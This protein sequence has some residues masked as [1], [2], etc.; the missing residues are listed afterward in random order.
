M[1]PAKVVPEKCRGYKIDMGETSYDQYKGI[2]YALGLGM[3]KDPL[4]EKELDFTFELAEN[5]KILPSFGTVLTKFDSLLEAFMAC[6]GLPDFNALN[7]LHG[8]Q[9]L[10][11]FKPFLPSMRLFLDGEI[12]DVADKVKG[13][14]VT[15]LVNI[16]DEKGELVCRTTANIFIRGIGGFGD[17]GLSQQTI[18][19]PPKRNPDKTVTETTDPNQAILYRLSGDYNPL[20]IAPQ[21]AQ[22]AGFDKPILHGLCFYG[23]ATKAVLKEFCDY[24]VTRFGSI[25]VMVT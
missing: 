16:K 9:K 14:L 22:V 17:K 21:M 19:A 13:A 7:I 11:S 2:L 8:E 15:A 10:E 5:F 1:K 24:D 3:S 18:P 23:I 4:D 20:H 6:P 12:S 25:A